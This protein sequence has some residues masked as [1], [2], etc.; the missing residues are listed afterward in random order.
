MTQIKT[1]VNSYKIEKLCPTCGIGKL[2]S[3]GMAMYFNFYSNYEHRCTNCGC[4]VTL[5]NQ[6]YPN[7]ITEE[8]GE[9]IMVEEIDNTAIEQENI[10]NEINYNNLCAKATLGDMPLLTVN[11][12][13]PPQPPCNGKFKI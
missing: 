2:V 7:I 9:P 4:V 6:I 8:I 12:I 10:V 13:F 1:Q 5:Q 11:D 3:T